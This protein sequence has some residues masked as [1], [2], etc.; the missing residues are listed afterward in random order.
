MTLETALCQLPAQG[1]LPSNTPDIIREAAKSPLGIL[2]LIVLLVAILAIRFF[3]PKKS[4]EKIRGWMFALIF[5]GV[6]MFGFAIS[7]SLDLPDLYR[8]K[9]IVLDVQGLPVETAKV[10]SAFGGEGKKVSGG[11]EFDIP[12]SAMPVDKTLDVY[13]TE[14]SAFLSGHSTLKLASDHNPITTVAL[15]RKETTVHGRVT[16]ENG[17]GIAGAII[18]IDGFPGEA[19]ETDKSGNFL[20]NAHA[21]ENQPVWL[22]VQKK[23]FKS[24]HQEH[25][26]GHNPASITLLRY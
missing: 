8:V 18:S 26:A 12:G 6:L 3:P 15:E 11:W 24:V 20:I 19:M 22:Q 14:D 2:A 9:V 10:W 17:E 13:A 16:D 23:G 5:A 21:A 1:L 7:R 4:S 25:F